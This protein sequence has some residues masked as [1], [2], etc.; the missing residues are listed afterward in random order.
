MIFRLN[1]KDNRPPFPIGSFKCE[2]KAMIVGEKAKILWYHLMPQKK[3]C[4]SLES[5]G[6]VQWGR[7]LFLYQMT[8][9]MR[10][11]ILCIISRSRGPFRRTFVIFRWPRSFILAMRSP[12]NGC[13]HPFEAFF[14]VTSHRFISNTIKLSKLFCLRARIIT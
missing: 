7:C 10:I 2:F 3:H 4:F 14:S 1:L 5:A 13:G 11:Y 9:L 8:A 6:K 12:K